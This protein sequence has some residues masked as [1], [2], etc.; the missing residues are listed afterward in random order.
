MESPSVLTR[1]PEEPLGPLPLWPEVVRP[2][3]AECT[4]GCVGRSPV[5][6]VQ[7]RGGR[8]M[9]AVGRRAVAS[10][11][12]RPYSGEQGSS[13]STGTTGTNW[14]QVA[15]PAQFHRGRCCL[16]SISGYGPKTF[17]PF[18]SFPCYFAFAHPK[19]KPKPLSLPLPLP[20]HSGPLA[21][22]LKCSY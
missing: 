22:A 7:R 5:A 13:G 6:W 10:Q 17:Q 3:E 15:A 16:L 8:Q 19:P 14:H 1:Q 20:L 9:W 11:R 2:M 18:K 21:S 4:G 12:P